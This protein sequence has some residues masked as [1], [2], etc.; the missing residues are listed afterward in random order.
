MQVAASNAAIGQNGAETIRACARSWPQRMLPIL[1]AA[2]LAWLVPPAHAQQDQHAQ[3]TVAVPNVI[4]MVRSQAVNTLLALGLKVSYAPQTGTPTIVTQ[5]PAAGTRVPVGS[6]VYLNKPAPAEPKPAATVTVPNVVG[7]TQEE[8]RTA[9]FRV[10][11]GLSYAQMM[12]VTTNPAQSGRVAAQQPA[13]GTPLAQGR[14]VTLQFYRAAA[15]VSV[16][17]V[18]GMEQRAAGDKL[19]DAG[20]FPATSQQAVSDA[21]QVGKVLRQDPAAGSSVAKGAQ[22]RL[23]VGAPGAKIRVP[24]VVGMTFGNATGALSRSGLRWNQMTPGIGTADA[25]KVGTVA[26]QVPDAGAEAASGSQV[27]IWFYVRGSVR[28][29]NVVGMISTSVGPKLAG[30][31]LR[32]QAMLP[33]APTADRAK[34]GTVQR[35]SPA[36][37]QEVAPGSTVQVWFYAYQAAPAPAATV[38]VPTVSLMTEADARRTLAAAGFNTVVQRIKT[39]LRDRW[40]KVVGMLPVAG[41]MAARGSTVTISVGMQ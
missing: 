20:L 25:A 22:V 10:G 21:A 11:L 17:N 39:P 19:R 2:L 32:G 6:F 18:V 5:S 3:A 24:N 27:Q 37:N 41:T 23:I 9:L 1:L 28:V 36:A 14:S 29:P 35:Q 4:G 26:R 31:G 13:A 40:G 15:A 16:P 7:M 34:H 38:R 33:N 8:A 30:V 12:A